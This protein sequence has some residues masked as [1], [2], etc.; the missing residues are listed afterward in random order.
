MDSQFSLAPTLF[1]CVMFGFF[2]FCKDVLAWPEYVQS[3][4][5]SEWPPQS[6]AAPCG[7]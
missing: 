4:R 6:V 7:P 3:N 2:N 1:N 5:T